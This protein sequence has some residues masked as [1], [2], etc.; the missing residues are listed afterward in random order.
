[1]NPKVAHIVYASDSQFID[2][3]GVSLVSL[4]GNSQDLEGIIVYI[5]EN[6]ISDSDKGRIESI[7]KHYKRAPIEWIPT[8]RLN[9]ILTMKIKNERGS[10]SQYSRLFISSSLPNDIDRVIYLDCD[11][12]VNES[13]SELWRLDMHNCI[14]SAGLDAFSYLY[15][16]NIDLKKNDNMF[17]SGVM[18]IDL[19]RWRQQEIEKQLLSFIS[20]KHGRVQ[21]GDQGALN[22]ILSK[23]AYYFEPRF[24]AVTAYF[25][26]SYDELLRYRKPPKGFYSR[27]EIGLAIEDPSIIHYTTSFL[28]KR[29]WIKGCEHKYVEKWLYYKSL[30]PWSGASLRRDNRPFIKRLIVNILMIFPRKIMICLCGLAQAYVRPIK[31]RIIDSLF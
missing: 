12:I 25:D 2:I 26:F 5:I 23:K 21:Q 18:L 16:Y 31:N 27:E 13:I 7:S 1:M 10:E 9:E 8:K 19:A 28:S 15:R 14:V 3:L 17:N 24:N 29:P 20:K 4:Y 11:V 22:A 6:G 30:S